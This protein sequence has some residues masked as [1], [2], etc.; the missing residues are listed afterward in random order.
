MRRAAWTPALTPLPF[1]ALTAL[2]LLATGPV[3]PASGQQEIIT[4]KSP[5][6]W[7][8]QYRLTLRS[9]QERHI[10]RDQRRMPEIDQW[11][12]DKMTM[13]APVLRESAG[14]R[15][16]SNDATT[17][18]LRVNDTE[19]QLS[20]PPQ[21]KSG[22]HSGA[23]YL[24]M[25]V[26]GAQGVRQVSMEMSVPITSW[27][28]EYNEQ[29]ANQMDW[30][31]QWPL[32][33]RSVFQPQ[34]WIDMTPDGPVDWAPIDNA[35]N[36]WTNGKDPTS[37]KPAILAKFLALEVIKSFQPSGNGV[38]TNRLGE[39]EGFELS[40]IDEAARRGRGSPFDMVNLLAGVYRR[41]GLPA[42]TVVGIRI[43]QEERGVFRTDK[44]T[45]EMHAWVEFAL[46][47]GRSV[48]WVPVDILEMRSRR[49]Q[50]RDLEKPWPY[51]GN[52]PDMDHYM[53]FAFH[54]HPPLEG[55]QAF[56]S[57]GFWGW[58]VFPEPPARADQAIYFNVITTPRRDNLPRE[59]AE[60]PR[61]PASPRRRR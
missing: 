52:Q 16:V 38:N 53:P 22:E 32:E 41:A 26:Q 59:Q 57:A 24:I 42:R 31:E 55:V 9:Y 51:F 48:T 47:D 46:S 15:I 60:E 20:A 8:I 50:L 43:E 25:G 30:P 58:I 23:Q 35:L 40:P 14:H 45:E 6:D 54:F 34:M 49:G 44:D 33:A 37:I 3:A 27:E 7:T 4:R 19:A 13:V 18:A 5:R 39:I 11:S 21:F 10:R 28:L 1:A 29:L 61:R 2:C 56:G 36:Q 17:V 12:W